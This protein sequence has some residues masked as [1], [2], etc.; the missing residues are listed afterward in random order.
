M[1]EFVLSPAAQADLGHIWDSTARHWGADQGDRYVFAI[2]DACEALANGSRRGR[3]I[4]AVRAGYWKL[5]MG[6]HFL[7]CRVAAGGV[8]EVV[9]ILHQQMD[10]TAHLQGE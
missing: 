7:F 8:V 5:P 10:V 6:S 4:D 3:A 1:S 2:R 9:R